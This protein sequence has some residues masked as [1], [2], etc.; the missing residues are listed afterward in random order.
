MALHPALASHL[1]DLRR[2]PGALPDER[3]STLDRIAQFVTDKRER[4]EPASLLFI[5]THNSRRSHM[6]Q[7]WAAVAAAYYEVDAVTTF[8]GGTEAT[9]F[10]PRAVA[11]LRRAGLRIETMAGDAENPHYEVSFSDSHPPLDAFSKKFGDPP[12]PTEGFAAIMTCS[13][14]DQACPFVEGAELRVALAYIDPKESDGTPRESA[15]YDA[16]S[17][18][19]ATEMLYL[20]ARVQ[21]GE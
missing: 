20:F 4:S 6:G 15:T 1:E 11:S 21:A 16:R 13:D 9:A 3:R 19:I 14:A 10:N 5:C 17:R 2:N 7:I 18:Q 8:S 12:N